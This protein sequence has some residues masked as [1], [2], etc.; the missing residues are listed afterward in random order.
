MVTDALSIV[1]GEVNHR[2]MVARCLLS[3]LREWGFCA[4]WKWSGGGWHLWIRD[5]VRFLSTI[6]PP[7]IRLTYDPLYRIHIEDIL[8][9]ESGTHTLRSPVYRMDDLDTMLASAEREQLNRQTLERSGA[10][11]T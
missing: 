10:G 7:I 2:K 4:G 5:D 9:A 8:D 3:L 1:F 11:K 6:A